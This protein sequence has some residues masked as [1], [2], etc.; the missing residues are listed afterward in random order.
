MED[1]ERVSEP[2]ELQ[3]GR[4]G[5]IA[6]YDPLEA[7]R[8]ECSPKPQNRIA[9]IG[10][11]KDIFGLPALLNAGR[12][13]GVMAVRN[14]TR[15]DR[16]IAP[17]I[18]RPD[19]ENAA[20]PE[21][22][23]R[24]SEEGRRI[25]DV[26]ENAVSEDK[27]GKVVRERP[28][29]SVEESKLVEKRIRGAGG[30]DVEADDAADPALQDTEIASQRNGIIVVRTPSTPNVDNDGRRI[31]QRANPCIESDRSVNIREAAEPALRIKTF[32]MRRHDGP[33]L[34]FERRRVPEYGVRA[35]RFE[36]FRRGRTGTP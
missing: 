18:R 5:L 6:V 17:R 33:R 9:P 26:L 8:G 36:A 4:L 19:A 3:V 30:I 12:D 35:R 21:D 34:P 22:S 1:T 10:C 32:L 13:S 16:D 14:E 25:G 24:I 11:R 7:V 27:I 23:M 31:Q 28:V 20:F 29:S 15:R 2:R